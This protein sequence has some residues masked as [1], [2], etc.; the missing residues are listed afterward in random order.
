MGRVM[1]GVALVVT[2]AACASS[3]APSRQAQAE[4]LLRLAGSFEANPP[5]DGSELFLGDTLGVSAPRA[6]QAVRVAYEDIGIPF[7]FYEAEQLRLGG[8]LR[9]LGRLDD[10]PPS[11]WVDC[12]RGAGIAAYA[13]SYE[14]TVT[15]GT[16]VRPIDASTSVV[17]TVI[18]A[19]A[20]ARDVSSDLLRCRSFGTF[21]ELIAERVQA[22]VRR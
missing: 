16:R 20:R 4:E 19:R 21:E 5:R 3:G 1:W 10:Q 14:V 18:R 22:N 13:D 2:A 6:F 15:V 8:I 7:S 11:T 17:E 9:P 12:G